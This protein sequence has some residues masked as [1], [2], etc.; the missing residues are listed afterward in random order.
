MF[1]NE[2]LQP[3]G[4]TSS[5]VPTGGGATAGA[6]PNPAS[7]WP[8][9]GEAVSFIDGE[10]ITVVFDDGPPLNATMHVFGVA[11]PSVTI[12]AGGSVKTIHLRPEVVR[13][14]PPPGADD[15]EASMARDRASQADYFSTLLDTIGPK[16]VAFA[17]QVRKETAAAVDAEQLHTAIR[18]ELAKWI[19]PATE[20]QVVRLE[21]EVREF[22]RAVVMEVAGKTDA[23]LPA[24]ADLN[25]LAGDKVPAGVIQQGSHVKV[26]TDAA[27]KTFIPG[28]VKEVHDGGHSFD[29]ELDSRSVAHVQAG[30]LALDELAK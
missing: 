2:N 25:L 20:V 16:L 28:V 10:K 8:P 9:H 17:K 27:Q 22:I 3:S 23:P 14:I 11:A 6:A 24:V 5:D 7:I 18:A 26:W 19:P 21:P 29:V 30:N 13:V 1:Q 12:D 15:F 4:A